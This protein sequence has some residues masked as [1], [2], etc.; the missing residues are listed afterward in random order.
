MSVKEINL[1]YHAHHCRHSEDLP[2]WENLAR[3]HPGPVLEL[4]C[5]TGRVVL[6]LAGK[7]FQ[8]YGLDRDGDML[9]VLRASLTP[10]EGPEVRIFQADMASFW[11]ELRFG[12]V[13]L[14]CNTYSTLLEDE[15]RSTLACARHHLRVD[16]VFATSLPNPNIL[17]SLPR[18][19]EPQVEE[20]FPHPVDGEPVQVSSS[21]QRSYKYVSMYWYYD[22]LLPDGRVKRQTLHSR[23]TLIPSQA[24]L[25]EMRQQGFASL[26]TYGDFDRSP[27]SSESPYLIILA[28]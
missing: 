5:G 9:A 2:F 15:R 6:Y 16:G 7:G 18:F 17:R 20:V 19:A 3:Q 23:H 25:D 4:G 13:L 10:Q 27:Y 14:P 26:E 12:L 28:S 21:W 22:H 8:V 11:L 1:L 24:Y